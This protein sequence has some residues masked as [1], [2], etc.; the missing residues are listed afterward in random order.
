MA[1]RVKDQKEYERMRAEFF[2]RGGR[3][4]RVPMFERGPRIYYW[5][6][7]QFREAAKRN[8]QKKEDK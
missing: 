6:A 5:V 2:A 4:K 3:I 8:A 1:R 7:P